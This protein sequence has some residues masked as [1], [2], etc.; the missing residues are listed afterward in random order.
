MSRFTSFNRL[1]ADGQP[2]PGIKFYAKSHNDRRKKE[3][4]KF[5]H[6]SNRRARADMSREMSNLGSTHLQ[7]GDGRIKGYHDF[8][9]NLGI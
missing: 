2:I 8:L 6:Q 1:G 7:A 9:N 4:R 3:A 5:R